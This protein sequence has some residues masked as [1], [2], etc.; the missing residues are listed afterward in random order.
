MYLFAKKKQ[1]Y[2]KHAINML[3][4]KVLLFGLLKKKQIKS[5]IKSLKFKRLLKLCLNKLTFI[6][7]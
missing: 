5:S 6:Y 4:I 1:E 2:S 7:F 3:R